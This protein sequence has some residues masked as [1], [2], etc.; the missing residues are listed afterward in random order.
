MKIV[1]GICLGKLVMRKL[2]LHA[3]EANLVQFSGRRDVA[4]F[5]CW[6]RKRLWVISGGIPNR[7]L[8]LA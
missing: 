8:D 5:C 2:P 4:T 3:R 7:I 6:E 1:A